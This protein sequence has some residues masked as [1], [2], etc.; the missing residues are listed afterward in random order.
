MTITTVREKFK[1]CDCVIVHE[2]DNP[3]SIM[4]AFLT[5]SEANYIEP[6]SKHWPMKRIDKPCIREPKKQNGTH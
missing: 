3:D 2:S 1:D 6:C 4:G 5:P